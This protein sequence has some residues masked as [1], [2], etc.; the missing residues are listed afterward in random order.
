MAPIQSA[1][2]SLVLPV[3]AS[4]LAAMAPARADPAV[5]MVAFGDSLM[6][7]YGLR[8][9]EA[10][11]AKLQQALRRNGFAVEV[12]N[13][14]VS[15]DTASAGLDRL[16]WSI[17]DGTQAVI[18][19]LGANDAL[20]GI[21]PAVTRGALDAILRRLKQRG[22]EVLL[23]G[24]RA[25]RNLGPDYAAAFDSI[26]P[27]LAARHGVMLYDF[28]LDGVA[29]QSRLNQPD[30][31][32]PTAAGVDVIVAGILPKTEELLARVRAKTGP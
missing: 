5:R 18:L 1:A 25:P 3:L 20:R 7:G 17:P 21:D 30:G 32:H 26:F 8:P 9:D 31:V 2:L 11:P 4:L 10:F 24:M 19:E 14:G 15:G 13:A 16:D 29:T 28:F 23:A 27:D 12:S 6:A 22:I